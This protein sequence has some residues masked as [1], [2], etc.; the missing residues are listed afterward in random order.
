MK[1]REILQIA[2]D[3]KR[4]LIC[5]RMRKSITTIQKNNIEATLAFTKSLF[6]KSSHDSPEEPSAKSSRGLF[7]ETSI[8][9]PMKFRPSP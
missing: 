1:K 8:Y 6:E 3:S 7:V 9:Y 5:D 2:F 4:N